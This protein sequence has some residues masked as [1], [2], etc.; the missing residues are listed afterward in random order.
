MIAG[1]M[2]ST[3]FDLESTAD[4]MR[5]Q[6]PEYVLGGLQGLVVIDEIQTRPDLFA[7]LRVLA[8]RPEQ[9]ARFLILGSAAPALIKNAS[10]SLAGRIEFVDLHGFDLSE[11][12]PDN[13]EML[14]LRGGFPRSY[15]AANEGDSMAWRE[16]LIQTCLQRDLPELGIRIPSP[17][18][19][20]FWT[21]LAH[22]HGKT[23]NASKLGRS[24]GVSDKTVCGYL[25]VLTKTFMVRQLQPWHVNVGKRQV[26]APKIYLR[27]TGLLHALLRLTDRNAL[28]GHPM[29]GFS[30]E[31]FAME[32]IMRMAGNPQDAYYWATYGGAELDLLMLRNGQWYGVEFKFSD[33]PSV[34]RSMRVAMEDLKLKKLW[35]IAPAASSYALA[36]GIDVCTLNDWRQTYAA[37][38][39]E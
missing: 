34:T 7:L 12:G 13:W 31:G 15:L 8:D 3:Y 17:A 5:L 28:L 16:G 20:R 36:P 33:A 18:I 38:G 25:D 27:D 35:I 26:K 11:V 9:K 2:D 23:W 10:E 37:Y 24:L 30:W 32:Q 14:W 1:E 6:N 19:R 4:N 21:M 22:Y 29:A 39:A